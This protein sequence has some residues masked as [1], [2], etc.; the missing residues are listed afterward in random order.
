MRMKPYTEIGV[1]RLKCF[2]CGG[3][4]HTQW[5]ICADGNQ[6]RPI[7]FFCD[8]DL[9]R[10]VLRFMGDPEVDAK[11]AAY[12]AE[13]AVFLVERGEPMKRNAVYTNKEIQQ[14]HVAMG[15]E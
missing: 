5:Q 1:R 7:C 10:C 2:R 9:N 3:R 8:V 15:S 11:M 13:V 6:Y 4:A 14:M 12:E